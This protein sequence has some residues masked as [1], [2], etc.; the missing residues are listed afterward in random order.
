MRVTPNEVHIDDRHWLKTLFGG[1][2][3]VSTIDYMVRA[4]TLIS[5]IVRFEIKMLRSR[6]S[7]ATTSEVSIPILNIKV[8]LC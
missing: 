3:T 2:G 4:V 8:S 6:I 1:P 5:L 7:L